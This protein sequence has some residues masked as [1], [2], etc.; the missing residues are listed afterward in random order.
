MFT[1]LALEPGFGVGHGLVGWVESGEARVSVT[2]VKDRG[3][4]TLLR[5]ARE[6]TPKLGS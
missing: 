1:E 5:S 6:P 3:K 2:W 4:E